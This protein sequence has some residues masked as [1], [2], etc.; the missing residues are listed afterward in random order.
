MAP[1]RPK[2]AS[3]LI[4][5]AALPVVAASGCGGGKVI[6]HTAA[7]IDVR[8]GFKE[9]GARRIEVHCPSGVDAKR[10]A[11]Y[12]CRA[13]TSRGSFRVIYTQIDDDGGV[14][15]PRL[16]RLGGNP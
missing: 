6:D 14:G 3:R 16:E 5:L 4:A 13:R 15:L 7:E 1:S 12:R 11:E 2:R 8:D 10:G 9:L